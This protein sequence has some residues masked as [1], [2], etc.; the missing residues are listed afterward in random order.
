MIN[1]LTTL[2]EW[3]FKPVAN[4]AYERGFYEASKITKANSDFWN[5]NSDFET[6]ASPERDRMRARARWLS[7]N[8]PIMDNIDNA[9]IN[10]VIGTGITLQSVTG[11]VKFDTDVEEAFKRWSETPSMCDATGRFTFY[12]IQRMILKSRMVDGELFVYKKITKEG[13]TLQLIEA[14]A[15]DSGRNDGGIEL[16]KTGTPIAYHFRDINGDTFSIKAEFIINYFTADRPSQV[17]GVSEYKQAILD[18]K[19]FSAFQ[20]ASIQGARARANIAYTVQNSGGG[21]PYGADMQSQIQ[22]IN[23][24]SVLYMKQGETI[25]KLDP[26]SVAT[27]YVQFSENTIR[28]IATARKISY[29]LAFRDYSKVNFASS[30]ASLL[31]DFKRFDHDQVHLTLHIL[32]DVFKTWL[33]VESLKGTIKAS[34][35]QKSPE[36]WIKPRWIMPVRSLVDPL[37]EMVALEKQIALN[38]TTETDACMANGKDYE[39]VLRKKA[40]EMKLKA[41]YGIPDLTL[42]DVDDGSS[43]DEIDEHM[44]G[45]ESKVT[46]KK[47][48]N[49]E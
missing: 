15:I 37:K 7:A 36:K 23:G 38:L 28:L 24:V 43:V 3:I 47:G 22:T 32:N 6:T 4:T 34:G 25:N 9:I 48:D 21:N 17:R 41:T 2:R 14:D 26:D 11:K 16:D 8:N 31:Q 13:L 45:S 29:E 33:E 20:T 1:P 46:K 40:N 49:D 42:L 30:R 18:I 35:M 44:T 39:E 12:D 10:N 5:S 19:N 27:D